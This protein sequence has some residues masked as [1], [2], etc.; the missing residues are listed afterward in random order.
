V[1]SLEVIPANVSPSANQHFDCRVEV[2][3]N[4]KN[5]MALFCLMF[6]FSEKY[7]QLSHLDSDFILVAFLKIVL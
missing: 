7:H 6:L 1:G 3:Q 5:K 2:C 4:Q